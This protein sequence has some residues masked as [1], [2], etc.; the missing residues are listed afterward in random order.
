MCSASLNSADLAGVRDAYLI[1]GIKYV[2]KIGVERRVTHCPIGV[3][4]F[5]VQPPVDE[6]DVP[7]GLWTVLNAKSG[8]KSCEDCAVG[9][10]RRGSGLAARPPVG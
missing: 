5:R 6:S 2:A 4:G 10:Q 8:S 9:Q 3:Q 7:G 1:L